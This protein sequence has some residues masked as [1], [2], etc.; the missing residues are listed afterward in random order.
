MNK[1]ILRSQIEQIKDGFDLVEYV[2]NTSPRWERTRRG[3]V[4][5]CVA[6]DERNPSMWVTDDMWYCFACGAH[7]DSISYVMVQNDIPFVEALEYM[8]KGKYVKREIK[9]RSGITKVLEPPDPRLADVYHRTLKNSQGKI[10]YLRSRGLSDRTIDKFN[11][12]YGRPART[13]RFSKPR[14][15]IPVY[16]DG[17]LVTVR[18]RVDPAFGGD[19]KYIAM[20]RTESFLFNTDALKDNDGFVVYTGSQIDAMLLDQ[21]GIPAVGSAGEGVFKPGWGELFDGVRTAILLDNDRAGEYGAIK[22]WLEIEDAVIVRWPESLPKGY[23]IND[24]VM[25]GMFGIG[26]VKGMIYAALA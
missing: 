24:A 8:S 15:T 17:Q 4:S 26:A 25:D 14:Y 2:M 22:A 21:H 3:I 23:D 12:G 1:R 6:H 9:T 5:V 11:L 7:G 10:Q 20:P 13:N 18:Y 19:V 16:R